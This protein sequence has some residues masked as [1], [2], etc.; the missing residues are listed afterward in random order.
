MK[1][2]PPLPPPSD[3]R[4]PGYG[5][6]VPPATGSQYTTAEATGKAEQTELSYSEYSPLD[7]LH[8]IE[9]DAGETKERSRVPLIKQAQR[10]YDSLEVE[11]QASGAPVKRNLSTI[12]EKTERTVTDVSPNWI[13]RQQYMS[14]SILRPPSSV[15]TSYGRAVGEYITAIF[16]PCALIQM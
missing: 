2:L 5:E 8:A 14:L 4:E 15:T 9:E 6:Y 7:P 10:G 11:E 1:D 12:S 13:P 16:R 3:D